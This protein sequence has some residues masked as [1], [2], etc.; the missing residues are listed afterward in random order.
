MMSLLSLRYPRMKKFLVLYRAPTEA[1]D[2]M[3]RD[4][5]PDEQQQ[6][7]DAWLNWINAHKADLVDA[8]SMLGKNMRVTSSGSSPVR[9]E[10]CG[11]SILQAESAEAAAA[12]LADS[13][14]FQLTGA[15]IDVVEI[16]PMPS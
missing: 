4:A 13:P 1:I 2:Q 10:D 8:G 9:N 6:G 14:M 15:Y 16:L 7:T 11:Y 5:T 12:M 3:M